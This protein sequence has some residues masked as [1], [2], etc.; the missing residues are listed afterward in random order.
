LK[1]YLIKPVAVLLLV[2]AVGAGWWLFRARERAEQKRIILSHS[3]ESNLTTIAHLALG[4]HNKTDHFPATLEELAVIARATEGGVDTICPASKVPYLYRLLQD[5][6]HLPFPPPSHVRGGVVYESLREYLGS[7]L[8]IG[9][10]TPAHGLSYHVC[11]V[12][13]RP[14]CIAQLWLNEDEYRAFVAASVPVP[15]ATSSDKTGLHPA[16]A[17]PKIP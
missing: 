3:C 11:L 5:P 12:P 2:M 15:T 16:P 10:A 14:T 17:P 13:D 6:K 4:Q 1:E 8:M 7:F 9:D